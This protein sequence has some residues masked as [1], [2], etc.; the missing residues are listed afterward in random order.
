MLARYNVQVLYFAATVCEE[1]FHSG[2]LE[3]ALR[4]FALVNSHSCLVFLDLS[5]SSL[6]APFR[7]CLFGMCV[8][9]C[10]CQGSH[11]LF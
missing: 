11:V 1:P 9:V 8:C 10:V 7:F 5:S 2:R 4:L 6:S 3:A